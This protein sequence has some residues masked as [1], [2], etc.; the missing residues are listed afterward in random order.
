M[1]SAVTR[2]GIQASPDFSCVVLLQEVLCLGP[3]AGLSLPYLP[4]HSFCTLLSSS[5][6]TA[7]RC[8]VRKAT[9]NTACLSVDF[10]CFYCVFMGHIAHMFVL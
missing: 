1:A 8:S 4:L 2:D 6:H 5:L 9:P 7:G 3:V 10:W